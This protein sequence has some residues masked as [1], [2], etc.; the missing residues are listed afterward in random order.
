MRKLFFSTLQES[1]DCPKFPKGSAS[2]DEFRNSH[3]II[4]ATTGLISLN[5]V[6]TS[7]RILRKKISIEHHWVVHLIKIRIITIIDGGFVTGFSRYSKTY[8][9]RTTGLMPS[10]RSHSNNFYIWKKFWLKCPRRCSLNQT[11]D[12]VKGAKELLVL[13]HLEIQKYFL[14]W[15]ASIKTFFQSL[16]G[17][18]FNLLRNFL[19]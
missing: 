7:K 8:Y 19:F 15:I 9:S 17:Q 14:S 5:S 16:T 10:P 1:L 11:S 13:I 6:I 2:L 18:T 3:S 12:N 4:S